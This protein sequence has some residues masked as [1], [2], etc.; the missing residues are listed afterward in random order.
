MSRLLQNLLLLAILVGLSSAALADVTPDVE[1]RLAS[2]FVAV[3]A[4]ETYAGII[5]R[6]CGEDGPASGF[7]IT[8]EGWTTSLNTS[9]GTTNLKAGDR[10]TIEFT[11]RAVDPRQKITFSF[12]FREKNIP[13]AMDLSDENVSNMTQGAPVQKVPGFAG[14]PGNPSW[15]ETDKILGT[16]P[17]FKA[18]A[19][20]PLTPSEWK[21]G[22]KMLVPMT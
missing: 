18:A 1:V 9:L 21:F 6:S 5:E 17:T 3:K 13:F 12:D 22:M 14:P 7:A 10:L 8:S 15:E 19:T 2:P 20:C 16:K 11:A 4:G